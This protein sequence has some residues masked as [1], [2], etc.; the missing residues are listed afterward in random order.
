MGW[1][2]EHREKGL[3]TIDLLAQ[4][5]G[6]GRS[7]GPGLVAAQSVG[8]V[9]YI[10]YRLSS[11]NITAI[12]AITKNRPGDWYNW[13]VKFVDESCGPFDCS[14]PAKILS[15]LTP[16]DKLVADGDL[17]ESNDYARQW[18]DKCRRTLEATATMQVGAILQFDHGLEYPSYYKPVTHVVMVDTKRRLG[19]PCWPL[20]E[21][22]FEI[23]RGL[24]RLPTYYRESSYTISKVD[25]PEWAMVH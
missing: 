18:R 19:R 4:H 5:I 12:I 23:S 21:G 7:G 11:G 10:A 16:I 25:L 20:P 1:S 15:M 8:A 14:C 17:S 2:F 6:D 3:Q 13:G 9:W 22:G 24:V